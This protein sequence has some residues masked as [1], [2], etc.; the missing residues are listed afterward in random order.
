[1]DEVIFKTQ[2][3]SSTAKQKEKEKSLRIVCDAFECLSLAQVR[4]YSSNPSSM[5]S[6]DHGEFQA[7][8]IQSHPGL[9][10]ETLSLKNKQNI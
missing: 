7:Q 4:V 2:K 5:L 8:K 9:H 6:L 1:M 3:I 10:N